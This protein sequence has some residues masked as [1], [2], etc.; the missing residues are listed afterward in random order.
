MLTLADRIEMERR[1][2]SDLSPQ[3]LITALYFLIGYMSTHVPEDKYPEYLKAS[4]EIGHRSNRGYVPPGYKAPVLPSAEDLDKM[5][6]EHAAA[7]ATRQAEQEA[8]AKP[9]SGKDAAAGP[10]R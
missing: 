5:E 8:E 7:K 9:L 2:F 10:D 1:A 4:A 6:A 3:Q